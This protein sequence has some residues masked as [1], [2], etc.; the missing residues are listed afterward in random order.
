MSKRKTADWTE[1]LADSQLPDDELTFTTGLNGLLDGFQFDE[2]MGEGVEE[3]ARLPGVKG[4]SG[5]PGEFVKSSE[6]GLDL[7]ELTKD[8]SG[9]CLDEMLSEDEGALP[10]DPQEKEAAS[11]AD[12]DWFDPTQEQ[13]PERLPRS[14]VPNEIDSPLEPAEANALWVEPD[15]EEAWGVDRRTNGLNL[16]PNKDLKIVEYEESVQ[17]GPKSGLPQPVTRTADVKDVILRAMRRSHYGHNLDDIKQELVQ[18]LGEDARHTRKAMRIIEDEHGLAGKVFVRASAFPGLRNGKWVKDLRKIARTARYIITTDETVATKMGMEAVADIREIPWGIS[19]AHYAPR[20]QAGGYPL[21]GANPR[22]ILKRAF[23]AGPQKKVHVPTPKPGLKPTVAS[24][25]QAQDEIAKAAEVQHPEIR[26]TEQQA[27]DRKCRS[28]LI[29]IA[30]YVRAERLSREDAIRIHDS[31]VAPHQ[32]LRTAADLML[33]SNDTPV[34]GGSGTHL[35]KDAQ[36]AR[37]R[38][39]DS[40]EEK[41]A[42]VDVVLKAKLKKHLGA[43]VSIGLFTEKEASL[44]LGMNKTA[45]EKLRVIKTALRMISNAAQG[46]PLV[47]N[48]DLAVMGSDEPAQGPESGPSW[49]ADQTAGGVQIYGGSGAHL[50]KDAQ[51]ARQWVWDSLKEKQAKLE[52]DLHIKLKKQLGASVDAGLLTKKEASRIL[53]LDKTAG[54]KLKIVRVA[55]QAAHEQRTQVVDAPEAPEYKGTVLIAAPQQSRSG[56][57]LPP[58][59]LEVQKVAKDSGIRVGE[60]LGLVR[61]TRQKMTEGS[62]GEELDQLLR[63]RFSSP[64]LKAGDGLLQTARD[65]HEGLSGF[66]YVDAAAYATPR[67]SG[68]CEKH[69]SKHRVNGIKGVL[70]MSRCG[71]CVFA[72]ADGVCQQYNKPLVGMSGNWKDFQKRSI[73]LA[74]APDHEVTASLFDSGEFGLHNDSLDDIP[75]TNSVSVKELG[76]VLFGGPEL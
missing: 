13:D 28:A 33:S 73:E 19:L 44:I 56:K 21:E 30:Q 15:L 12:L 38:V 5:L 46:M 62:A 6:E 20:F 57:A 48:K 72:N 9:F 1:Y 55:V 61:W 59:V 41:Q 69:A 29:Q 35:S 14:R 65:E 3:Q 27:G 66:V 11:M 75:L 23:L 18:V 47:P 49:S 74:D 76:D 54:E 50:P 34:Y 25:E 17:A 63:A 39:W 68:G 67:G 10:M 43:V 31:E 52:S 37:Q 8:D 16:V 2:N 60:F 36:A 71:N 42:Q 70:E 26:T 22:E 32:M 7:E 4:L 45:G 24:V 53:A 51:A 64:L 58:E 40:L